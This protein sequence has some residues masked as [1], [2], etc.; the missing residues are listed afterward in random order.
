MANKLTI[1]GNSFMFTGTLT[2]L[3]RAEAERIVKDIGGTIL[4]G[5]TS[6]LNILVVGQDAGSKL[7]KAKKLGTVKILSEKDFMMMM[8]SK[9]TATA[10]KVKPA[11]ATTPKAEAVAPKSKAAAPKAKTETPKAKAVAQKGKA[12][13]QKGK[14]AR[15][16]APKA[17]PTLVSDETF[18]SLRIG[19][20]ENQILYAEFNSDKVDID[21]VKQYLKETVSFAKSAFDNIFSENGLLS[22]KQ[23][24]IDYTEFVELFNPEVLFAVYKQPY[25]GYITINYC[26]DP[27]AYIYEDCGNLFKN[28]TLS[29]SK[30]DGEFAIGLS[31]DH[32]YN[33]DDIDDINDRTLNRIKQI[34]KKDDANKTWED[35]IIAEDEE[36][37]LD[38]FRVLFYSHFKRKEIWL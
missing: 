11:K 7:L 28:L 9:A 35:L 18:S 23:G 31:R 26:E 16:V 2:H 13:A 37:T 30:G 38:R 21:Q 19:R 4:S 34:I 12:V 14:A 32:T 36:V 24:A 10:S 33:Y 3:K 5:V 22:L 17:T 25:K 27:T 8:S 29:I 15:V 20:T 6:K 1:A